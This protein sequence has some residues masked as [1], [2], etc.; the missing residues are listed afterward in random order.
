[1]EHHL[2]ALASQLATVGSLPGLL[3]GSICR[4][5]GATRGRWYRAY[6]PGLAGPLAPRRRIR[7]SPVRTRSQTLSPAYRAF[8]WVRRRCRRGPAARAGFERPDRHQQAWGGCEPA[9]PG[10]QASRQS[11]VGHSRVRL[12]RDRSV[13]PVDGI[14]AARLA[15]RHSERCCRDAAVS[16]VGPG[17]DTTGTQIEKESRS[18]SERLAPS[19]RSRVRTCSS[20]RSCNSIRRLAS[21]S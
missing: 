5:S 13:R 6:Q 9:P 8:V 17:A 14:P 7:V 21:S 10:L 12:T 18:D 16:R 3:P 4:L 2:I 1:M 11:R 19:S 20:T 15:D